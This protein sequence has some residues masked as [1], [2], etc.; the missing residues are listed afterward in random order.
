MSIGEVLEKCIRKPQA[1]WTQTDKIRAARCLRSLGWE[2]YRERQARAAGMAISEEGGLMFPVFPVLFPV[3]SQIPA[4]GFNVFPMFSVPDARA[5]SAV[6]CIPFLHAGNT[7]NSGNSIEM[8]VLA[9]RA[10]V[11]QPWNDWEQRFASF[12][13]AFPLKLDTVCH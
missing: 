5:I 9:R 7:G 10:T 6:F 13:G 3:C 1:Q 12:G 4:N 2:R 8:E 11:E